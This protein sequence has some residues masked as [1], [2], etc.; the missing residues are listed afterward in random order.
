MKHVVLNETLYIAKILNNNMSVNHKD[1]PYVL[2]LAGKYLYQ[3]FDAKPRQIKDELLELV[4]RLDKNNPNGYKNLID[5]ITSGDVKR[6]PL[7]E[8][9]YVAITNW[10]LETIFTLEDVIERKV[11]FTLLCLAKYR[12]MCNANNNGWETY[13]FTDIFRMANVNL[14]GTE[15]AK[16]I[17]RLIVGGFIKPSKK[18]TNCNYQVIFINNDSPVALKITDYRDLGNTLLSYL[19]EDFTRCVIC[20]RLIKRTPKV[21][22]KKYCAD[23]KGKYM[24]SDTTSKNLYIPINMRPITT[25]CSCCGKEIH[26]NPSLMWLNTLCEDCSKI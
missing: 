23:C 6:K 9:P 25:K 11:C 2:T 20:G 18:I 15:R 14:S 22:R 1:I 8:I 5:K 10:E 13:E 24:Y 19:G 26:I 7:I 21:K 17:N 16:V 12:D 3:K 4:E